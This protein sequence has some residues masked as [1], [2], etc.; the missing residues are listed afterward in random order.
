METTYHIQWSEADLDRLKE[1]H[2]AHLFLLVR[3]GRIVYVGNSFRRKIHKFI[4]ATIEAAGL[5][6]GQ[7]QVFLGRIVEMKGLTLTTVTSMQE[8]IA[9]ARKPIYNV[10]GKK[11]Y[12]STSYFTL[13]ST[14]CTLM[15]ESVRADRWGVFQSRRSAAEG[16]AVA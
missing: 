5:A 7:T 13:N 11:S 4:P 12:E 6:N 3:N 14:G 10:R 16:Y 9:F 15:P 8:L 2:Y 1:E